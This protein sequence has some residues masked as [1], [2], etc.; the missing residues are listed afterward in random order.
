MKDPVKITP[1][2]AERVI[3]IM[4]TKGIPEGYRLRIAIKGGTGCFGI[5]YVV[6]FDKQKE[7]DI[8]YCISGVD[9][10]VEKRHLMFLMGVTMDYIA[11]TEQQGFTFYK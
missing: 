7:S 3:D 1:L 10:L 8:L 11:D 9:V 2:A 6:G 4:K 5:N